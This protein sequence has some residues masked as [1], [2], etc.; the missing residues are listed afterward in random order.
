MKQQ[1]DWVGRFD[2]WVIEAK[3]LRARADESEVD[4]MTFLAAGEAAGL[5]REKGYATFGDMLHGEQI[6][7][8]HRFE[9][10]KEC[11]ERT[12]VDTVRTIGIEQMRAAVLPIPSDVASR[13]NPSE[14]AEV[15][16]VKELADFT[17]R[18]HTTP[19]VQQARAIQ[20]KHWEP[21]PKVKAPLPPAEQRVAELM[22][23]NKRLAAENR[24]L[25]RENQKLR[26]RLAG[27]E[28]DRAAE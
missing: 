11:V 26:D 16:V 14:R 23:E 17:R 8:M 28:S 20:R 2:E 25:T 13:A 4:F 9:A 6:C 1:S 5:H 15:L 12:S 19:S 22:K 7:K 3:R 18:N 10:Y 21:P 27:Y 24:K